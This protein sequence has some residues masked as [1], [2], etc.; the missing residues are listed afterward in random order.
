[1]LTVEALGID[2]VQLAH[3]GR[4]IAIG[5]FDY[6]MIGIAHQ[7]VGVTQPVQALTDRVK[8]R[9]E[10]VAVSILQ[11]DIG[12]AI[13]TRGDMVERSAEFDAQ[14]SS[15]DEQSSKPNVFVQDLTPSFTN[16]EDLSHLS[17]EREASL[18][19]PR[20]SRP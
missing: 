8:H 18:Q 3:A 19:V 20:D 14:G 2:A 12:P 10:G 5:G 9:E 1:M 4:Q 11:E 17:R 13:A 15:H 7:A 16:Q 6:Q